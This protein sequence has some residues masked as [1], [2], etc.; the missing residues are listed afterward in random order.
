MAVIPGDP[1][2]KGEASTGPTPQEVN[3]YHKAADKD[4]SKNA[5]HHTLGLRPNQ[6][7]AGNHTHNAKDSVKI[8]T[9]ENFVLTGAKGGNVALTNLIALLK[10]YIQFIDNTT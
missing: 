5:L 10:N 1:F 9:N 2:G 3:A 7:A 4:A 6:A 8:G